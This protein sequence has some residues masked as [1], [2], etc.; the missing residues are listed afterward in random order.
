MFGTKSCLLK[1]DQALHVVLYHP[2]GP[3][4]FAIR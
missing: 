4:H 1:F 2:N 3:D